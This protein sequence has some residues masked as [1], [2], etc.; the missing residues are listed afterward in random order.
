[1][2]AGPL[3]PSLQVFG[4]VMGGQTGLDGKR[5]QVWPKQVPSGAEAGP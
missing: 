2:P 1:M 4:G 5:R 3:S